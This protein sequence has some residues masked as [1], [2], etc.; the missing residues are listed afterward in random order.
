MEATGASQ[1]ALVV[2]EP[3][4]ECRKHR[5]HR[6]DPW[7][8]K[9]PWRKVWQPTPV[10]FPGEYHGQSNPVGNSLQGQKSWTRLNNLVWTHV[11]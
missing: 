8:R 6:F 1:V 10:V 4:Y 7:V 9:I 11:F 5:K 3:T 2:K